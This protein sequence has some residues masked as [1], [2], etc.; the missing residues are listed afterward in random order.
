MNSELADLMI[1]T[2]PDLCPDKLDECTVI[3]HNWGSVPVDPETPRYSAKRGFKIIVVNRRGRPAYF[4][5]CGDKH[6]ANLVRESRILACLSANPAVA[7][8]VP[9][10]Y[11]GVGNRIRIVASRNVPGQPYVRLVGDRSPERWVRDV[12]EILD[13]ARIVGEAALTLPEWRNVRG[14]T[15]QLTSS[16]GQNLAVLRHAGLCESDA[17]ILRQATEGTPDVPLQIQHGDLW[18]GNVIRS[19]RKWSLVDFAEFG[20]VTVVMYDLFHMLS[21]IPPRVGV[22]APTL[23]DLLL[24]ENGSEWSLAAREVIH[25]ECRILGLQSDQVLACLIYYLSQAGRYRLR[26]GVPRDLALAFVEEL[27]AVGKVLR[28]VGDAGSEMMIARP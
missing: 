25:H 24:C 20:L 17:M 28:Q 10:T 8:I 3:V 5:R 21:Y 27:T 13:V 26:P 9:K 7:D 2:I 19:G 1:D 12:G 15:T 14:S 16:I 18:P 11:C 4:V 6:D 23:S 22:N